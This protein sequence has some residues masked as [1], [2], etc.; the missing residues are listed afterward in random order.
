MLLAGAGPRARRA[1]PRGGFGVRSE[2]AE[3]FER[4]GEE[5]SDIGIE[6]W[7]L[8]PGFGFGKDIADNWELLENLSELKACGKPVLVGVSRKRMTY[9]SAEITEK[10]HRLALEQGADILRVHDVPAA[11]LTL[12]HFLSE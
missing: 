12:E 7:I 1:D 8:D 3:F 5:A 2:V 6:D 9:G 4:W 11:R 10:A